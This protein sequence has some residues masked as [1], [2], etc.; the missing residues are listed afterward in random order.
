MNF[1][2]IEITTKRG[3]IKGYSYQLIKWQN[4]KEALKPFL[5]NFKNTPNDCIIVKAPGEK[6]AIF[7]KNNSL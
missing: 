7:T 3:K 4:S 5:E 2:E 6:Y 1:K